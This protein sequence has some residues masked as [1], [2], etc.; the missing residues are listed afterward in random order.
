MHLIKPQI[1]T[2]HLLLTLLIELPR[3]INIVPHA[4]E[5]S[6]DRTYGGEE[7]VAEPDGE[8]CVF[9][10]HALT[11][12]NFVVEATPHHSAY[13]KLEHTTEE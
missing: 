3:I 1:F 11:A 13:R 8:D 10:P 12:T 7:G 2:S 4:I 5:A 9:L 6:S